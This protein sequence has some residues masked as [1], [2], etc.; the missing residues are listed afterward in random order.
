MPNF[1]IVPDVDPRS[2]GS[3]DA[4]E[5]GSDLPW[6]RL[7]SRRRARDVLGAAAAGEPPQQAQLAIEQRAGLGAL[8]LP[9]PCI[10]QVERTADL[11]GAAVRDVPES[12]WIPT[13]AATTLGEVEHDAAGRAFDLIG[14]LRAVRPE[15]RDH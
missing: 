6:P 12:S 10:R 15:L 2:A 5:L 13:M 9:A 7:G 11:P 3:T 1:V 4:M 14:G 8:D